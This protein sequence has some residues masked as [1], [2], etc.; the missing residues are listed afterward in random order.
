MI[1][2][3]GRD[4]VWNF[5][6]IMLADADAEAG[7]EELTGKLWTFPEPMDDVTRIGIS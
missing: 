4:E 6:M 2:A 1:E 3:I 7:I 5:G